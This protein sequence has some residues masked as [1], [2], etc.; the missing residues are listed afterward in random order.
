MGGGGVGVG[1]GMSIWTA[2]DNG[3]QK[4]RFR[5][6][7]ILHYN[8]FLKKCNFYIHIPRKYSFHFYTGLGMTCEQIKKKG[9]CTSD[10][11]PTL[12]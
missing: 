7:Q 11:K 6:K 5:S 8:F 2:D 4:K 10:E 12:I 3:N 9:A 1:G